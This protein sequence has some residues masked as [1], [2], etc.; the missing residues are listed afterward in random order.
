MTVD[1]RPLLR[2]DPAQVASYRVVGRLG[3]GGQGVVYLGESPGGER[4]AI[5]VLTRALEADARAG[6]TKEIELARRVK[7][8]CTASVL[9]T[10][11]LDGV[12]YVISEFVDGPSL[13]RVLAERGPL[14]Q[15][16]LRRL[17]IGSLTALAAIHQAGVVH[18]DFKPGNVL[19]GR[20]GPRVI[21]FGISRALDTAEPQDDL[22]GTPPYMAPEQF[23]GGGGPPADLF[24]WAAT[25]V[26]AATGAPPFGSGDLPALLNR[27]L[28]AEPELGD[29]RGDLREVVAGCLAKDPAARP[30]ASAALLTLLGHPVQPQRLLAE[31]SRSAA[32]PAVTTVPPARRARRLWPIAAGAAAVLLVGAAVA[33]HLGRTADPPVSG[34]PATPQSAE[35][36]RRP[37]SSTATTTA[38]IPGTKIKV[39]EN[40]ADPLWVTSAYG[41][42]EPDAGFPAYVRDP[43]TGEFTY[44]GNFQTP[45]VSPRGLY[46]A[47]TSSTN[48]ARSDYNTLRLVTRATGEDVELRTA[49]KP[50]DTPTMAWSAD[51][52]SLLLTLWRSEESGET[53][54][55]VTV[56][57]A[58]KSVRTRRTDFGGESG[59]LWGADASTLMTQGRDGT[60]RFVGLDGSV[61]RSFRDKGT[62]VKASVSTTRA[63]TVFATTCTETSRDVCLWDAVTGA[64]KAVVPLADGTTF[65]GWLDDRHF[66]ATV[67]GARTSRLVMAGLDGETV[68]VL[69]EGPAAQLGK[70]ALWWSL[71]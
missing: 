66:L 46:V 13:A 52:A 42:V 60:I 65:N 53:L 21:D 25:V 58:T 68:R 43:R 32:P 37:M 24:S 57:P 62:L 2:D 47:A 18:R 40:P 15:A 16:E 41:G 50:G 70:V 61:L 3:E 51:G 35:P 63:G 33:I 26:C 48:L 31:G 12:P 5:K 36:S 38:T 20:E 39:H 34:P 14:R 9:A 64:R 28:T 19:L 55:F 27:V 44:F 17:A 23:A 45:V 1:P 30:A 6:F 8:F 49:D 22:T 10:G 7:A 11:E 4:V 69:A 67:T 59:Y 56:D 29:L 54:G 71:R